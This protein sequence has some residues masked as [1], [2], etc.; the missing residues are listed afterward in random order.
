ML[1][2]TL[3]Q[4]LTIKKGRLKSMCKDTKNRQNR[5]EGLLFAS[6]VLATTLHIFNRSRVGVTY[7]DQSN[8]QELNLVATN[9]N[10]VVNHQN[11]RL[12]LNHQ[13][14]AHCRPRD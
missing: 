2:A 5:I 10:L 13:A 14:E 6:W 4:L 9:L 3:S 1:L 8:K 11:V 7:A 12:P